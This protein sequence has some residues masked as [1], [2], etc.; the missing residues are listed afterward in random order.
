MNQSFQRQQLIRLC[1]KAEYIDYGMTI[2]QLKDSLD[3]SYEEIANDSFD[4]SLKQVNEYFLTNDLPNKLILRKLNDNIKRIYKDEQ[5][6]R[7]IIISQVKTLLSETCPFWLIKTDIKRFYESIDRERMIS[8]FQDDSMLS[9]QSRFLLKKVFENPILTGKS[10]VP[11]GMNISATMSELYMRKFDKWV[12]TYDSVYYYA[13]FVDDIIIF[14]NSIKDSL[15]LIADLNPK[16]NALAEGLSINQNKT[17]LFD[18]RSLEKLNI[19]NGNRI[20][21]SLKLKLDY[22]GY[23]FSKIIIPEKIVLK[24]FQN[25]NKLRYTLEEKYSIIENNPVSV[26]FLDTIQRE[27]YSSLIVSIADKKVKKIKTRI[28]KA[29]LDFSKN[30]NFDLLEKRIQFLTGNYSI[31]KSEEGNSLRAGIYYNYLQVTDHSVFIELNQLLRKSIFS[32]NPSFG[33]KIS[34]SKV[35]K[36]K[37]SKYCFIAG[38]ENKVHFEFS[39]NE[40]QDIIKC[41]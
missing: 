29:L 3:A 27:K 6:N 4:F 35:Q 40:M 39:Y 11:R 9:Y 37:L 12:R 10:G 5:A 25:I 2:N 21:K 20:H 13:R 28:I 19:M 15:N 7:R 33:A 34:L 24:K 26:I 22:L 23:S 31:R 16:L 38:F 1:K 36:N 41:W 8:K 18:G 32:R 14:S 30:K 17:E